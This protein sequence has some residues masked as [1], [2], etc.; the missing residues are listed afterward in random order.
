MMLI[1]QF[2]DQ[3][4][5]YQRYPLM[6]SRDFPIFSAMF[7]TSIILQNG[8]IDLLNKQLNM[9]YIDLLKLLRFK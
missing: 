1:Q 7:L 6:L 8:F 5:F 2:F 4:D 9:F 3:R